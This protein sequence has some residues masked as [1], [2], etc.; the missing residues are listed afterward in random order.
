MSE[1]KKSPILLIA[2]AA[3]AIVAGAAWFLTRGGETTPAAVA[4][5]TSETS[6]TV[7][8]AVDVGDGLP[9]FFLGQA[10]APVEVIEYASFTCPHCA[11]FHTQVYPNLKAEYIDT[12]K[13]KFVMREVYFDRYGLLAGLLARCGGDMRY[14]GIVDLLYKQQSEWARGEGD[15]IIQ[16]LYGIGRQ[17]G[18]QND[19]MQACLSDRPLSEALVADF[20][21]KAGR[22]GVNATPSFVINGK[23]MS[24]MGWNDFKAAIDAELN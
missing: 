23:K 18:L 17:A 24:N 16:N 6:E 4:Q 8:D 5:T 12:G 14:F 21:L 2:V 7:S 13:V 9:D 19:Q 22:D 15:A 20:Q 10:D 1:Q 3:V 11:N